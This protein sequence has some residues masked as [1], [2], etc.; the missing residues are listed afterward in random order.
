M[1]NSSNVSQFTKSANSHPRKLICVQIC[2]LGLFLFVGTGWAAITITG[3]ADKQVYAD[4]TSFTVVSESGFDYTAALNGISIAM[5]TAIDVDEPEYY[6]LNVSRRE[7]SS[8]TE[9]STLIRFIV[10]ASERLNTE[11]GLPLWTPYPM[12]D[13][14][15]AEYTGAQLEIVTPATYPVGLE[16]PVI[17]RLQ[18][19]AG[20]RLGV[21]GAVTATGFENQPL[22]LLRGVGSVFLPA[23]MESGTLSYAAHLHA[24][25]TPKQIEIE[26]TTT[27]QTASGTIASTTDWGQNGRIKITGNLAIPAGV[28]LTIGAGSVIVVSPD[29][30]IT[31]E[32]HLVVTGTNAQPVVFTAQDRTAPWGGFILE[33][34]TSQGD[35]SG[36]IFTASG[37][38]PSWFSGKDYFS[39]RSEQCIFLLSNNAQATLTDCYMV[40]NHGQ[41]GHG[42]YGYLTMTGCLVQKAVTVGQYNNGSVIFDD[43]ALIEFPAVRNSFLDA[44]NDTI[45][46]SGGPHSFTDCLIGWTLDDGIDAGQGDA[47]AVTV[48]GCWFESTIHEAMACSSGN[49]RNVTVTDTVVVNCGQAIECGYD[50]PFID[51]DHCLC[52]GNVVG[53]RFGDNYDRTYTGFLDVQNS[54]LLFNHRDVWGRAWDNWQLHLSQMDILNNYFSVP[55]D[56]YANNT[57]WDPQNEPTQ[58]DELEFFL[59]TP[60]ATVG[61]GIAIPQNMLDL[62]ELANKIPV[63]LST[64]TTSF[65]SVNYAVSTNIGPVTA[66]TLNFTPGQTVQHIEFTIPPTEDLRLVSVSLSSPVNAELTNYS[67]VTYQKPYEIAESLI[68]EGDT[69]EY[70]K[71]TSE[72]PADWNQP[73]FVPVA[74]WLAGPSGFGYEDSSGYGPCIA[75]DLTDMQDSY[76]SVYARKLFWIEDPARVTELTLTMEWDDGY[77]AYLNGV[78][79]DSQN[80]PSPVAYDEPASSDTHEACCGSGC[81]PDQADLSS[82]I[83]LLN[84]GFNVLA[85][86]AHNG[87]IDSS[88]FIF[89]PTLSS[90]AA[91]YAGDFEPDGDVDLTDLAVLA[92]A[93]LAQ[94]GQAR[95]NPICDI[96]GSS[97]GSINLL[98]LAVF[99][100]NWLTGS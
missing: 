48:D 71:G 70:F 66:G 88:D 83:G 78:P 8:G 58:L 18:N 98:D 9:E 86:Q 75:T 96:D 60:A 67:Q 20:K 15:A 77:I 65:V 87:T 74:A 76:F 51:A 33:A 95:Y 39:H 3:V 12:I 5:D 57:I 69:W 91:P 79:V 85:I 100:Q 10:R 54:L 63:R 41:I 73:A 94:A 42:E 4:T 35:F 7:Q 89:I 47:G 59:P 32:G 21:N 22:Q 2:L 30:E 25:E 24:L 16:I 49:P 92:E 14:A 53:A 97:D 72:P 43:C 17:A 31:V 19:P 45:Y 90:V 68:A 93:W 50:G 34:A 37:A 81:M 64:F 36:T 80:P 26:T 61:V 84:P 82:F 56:N 11:W 38:D 55:N 52:T 44:D 40:E 27:W 99:A 29:V 13:S 28:T 62:S 23:A 1:K 6:E 46:L